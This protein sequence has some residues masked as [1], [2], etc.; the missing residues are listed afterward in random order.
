MTAQHGGARPG[1][2]RKP[3][4]RL[5]LKMHAF[6]CSD[7]EWK[8][9]NELALKHGFIKPSGAPNVSEYIRKKALEG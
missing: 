9:I 5:P 4:G 2:G 8:K 7:E 6:K 1:A 3:T